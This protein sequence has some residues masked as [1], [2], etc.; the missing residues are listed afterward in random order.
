[1]KWIFA[2]SLA[3]VLTAGCAANIGVFEAH[4]QTQVERLEGSVLL[5]EQMQAHGYGETTFR[6]EI[7]DSSEPMV[8]RVDGQHP[9]S[10][11]PELTP[12]AP[13]GSVW[14]GCALISSRTCRSP[15]A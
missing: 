1:M 7:D 2:V 4:N 9:F 8:H 5:R 10:L 11:T 3:S 15:S 13:G 14:Y 12:E 6:V